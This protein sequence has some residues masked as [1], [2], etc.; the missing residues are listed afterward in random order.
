MNK[1][2]KKIIIVTIVLAIV[3]VSWVT[4]TGG[5]IVPPDIETPPASASPSATDKPAPGSLG[6]VILNAMEGTK[7]EYGIIVKNLK[8]GETYSANEHRIYEP[9][10]LYKLWVMAT[11]FSQIQSG[12]LDENEELSEQ[13][14]VLNTKFGVD[15]ETAELKEG[16]ITL[17]VGQAITQ[18]IT[19][20][21]NYASFLLLE[22]IRSSAIQS[23]LGK[24]GFNES[25]IGESPAATSYDI[26]LFFE[27]LYKGE[28]ANKENT[29]KMLAI[30]KK[31]QLNGGLP[32]YLP[33]EA[34]VAHKT[35]DIDW[36]KHDAGIVFSDKGNYIIVIM[37]ES[38][39]PAGAQER[40]AKTS[41]AVYDYFE[42]K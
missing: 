26:A 7:G 41:K 4:L 13:I 11:A 20:S 25:F 2:F 9:G 32:K 5:G 34:E 28:L 16:G 37:S 10:S 3:G 33:Q 21:H 40:I 18:M 22:K 30:L 38:D 6:D 36:L 31:Q 12:V 17:T 19:I 23:Y 8:T 1:I 35:G 24:N 27:K 42:G 29:E 14:S 15:P 39:S